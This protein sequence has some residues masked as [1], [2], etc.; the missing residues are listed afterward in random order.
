MSSEPQQLL[1][2]DELI[3]EIKDLAISHE[4]SFLGQ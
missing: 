2:S 3:L 4:N 1:S